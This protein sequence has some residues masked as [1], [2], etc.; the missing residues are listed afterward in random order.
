MKKI[1]FLTTQDVIG[2][3]QNGGMQC[4]ERNYKLL[5]AYIGEE[6]LYVRIIWNKEQN[7]I[8]MK[9]IKYF[10]RISNNKEALLSACSCQKHICQR[11]IKK[12]YWILIG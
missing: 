3:I 7:H 5:K 9:N 6:N 4:A 12:L 10:R 11:N 1:L 8:E 2:E